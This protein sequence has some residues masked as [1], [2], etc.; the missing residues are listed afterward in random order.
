MRHHRHRRK[1]L[2]LDLGRSSSWYDRGGR[3]PGPNPRTR[4]RSRVAFPET[5]PCLVTLKV[6]KRVGS[7]RRKGTVR[8]IEGS[9]RE[10]NDR[11]DFRLVVYSVQRD[12]VHL[13]VEAK[14]RGALGRGMKAIASRLARAVNRSLGRSSKVL[15]DRYH[16]R[17]LTNARQVWNTISYV[18]SNARRHEQKDRDAL[19]RQGVAVRPLESRGTLDGASSARWFEGWRRDVPIDRSPPPGLSWR[20]VVAEART[21]LLREGWRRY[22]FLDPN[23]I[24]GSLA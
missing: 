23:A 10:A 13:I 22:G 6:T 4:H 20:C 24:P 9:F 2:S 21:W 3:P 15:R 17:V 18:L 19:A 8:E 1:Q 14:D 16:L 5:H 7:L 12:H 11:G